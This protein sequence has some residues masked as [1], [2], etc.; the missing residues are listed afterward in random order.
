MPNALLQAAL[1]TWT[2]S[3]CA[4]KWG[5]SKITSRMLCA[6]NRYS[7]ACNGDSGGPLVCKTAES[8][9]WVLAGLVSWGRDGCNPSFGHPSVFA[10][11]SS[12]LGWINS[13]IQGGNDAV[14]IFSDTGRQS[15][16]SRAPTVPRGV[17]PSVVPP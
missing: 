3:D 13:V 6:G 4:N 5:S 12:A 17:L 8:N 7:G 11:V 14:S 15:E 1:P 10:R 16:L 2:V 9:S